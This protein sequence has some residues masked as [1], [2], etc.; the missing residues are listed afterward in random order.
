MR[1]V[2]WGGGDL[3]WEWGPEGNGGCRGWGGR[4]A[5]PGVGGLGVWSSASGCCRRQGIGR[6]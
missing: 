4:Q 3:G 1:G 5:G 2:A 6:R